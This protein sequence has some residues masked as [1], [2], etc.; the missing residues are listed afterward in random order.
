M[1]KLLLSVAVVALLAVGTVAYSATQTKDTL[2]SYFETGDV[3]TQ[4]EFIDLIDS[5]YRWTLTGTTLSPEDPSHTIEV[6]D[7]NVTGNVTGSLDM[8]ADVI[9][10]IGATNTNFTDVGGLN[11]GGNAVTKTVTKTVCASN[12]DN[13][14]QCD[15]LCDGTADDIQIQEALDAVDVVSK[16][17]VKVISGDYANTSAITMTGMNN[18]HLIFE[19]GAKITFTGTDNVIESINTTGNE[20]EGLKISGGEIEGQAIDTTGNGIHF[21]FVDDSVIEDITITK[22]G[23]GV[24]GAGIY[25]K[26]SDYNTIRASALNANRNGFLSPQ[27]SP[28]TVGLVIT[29]TDANSNDDDGIH[30]QRDYSSRVHDCVCQYN[31]ETGIDLWDSAYAVI[32]SNK[33]ASNGKRGI[34]LADGT[35]NAMV[36]SN[37]IRNNTEEGVYVGDASANEFNIVTGNTIRSNGLDGVM[38][39]SRVED[40]LIANNVIRDNGGTT[41]SGLRILNNT[42]TRRVRVLNNTIHDNG[43]YGVWIQS[44]TSEHEVKGNHFL[45]NGTGVEAHQVVN[46][47]GALNNISGNTGFQEKVHNF[48]V[49]AIT[50]ADN[51][52]GTAAVYTLNPTTKYASFTCSDSDGC[53]ITMGETAP[54]DGSVNRITNT[55]ANVCNFADSA[56]RSE[57]AGSFA[58]G[59]YDS[60]ELIYATDRWTEISRS[61]N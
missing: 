11:L 7:F 40:L 17:S 20:S 21:E 49:E 46:S 6:G 1:K 53:N 38:V 5:V 26:F 37:E 47:G 19:E 39:T 42:D 33:L 28:S 8:D 58:M 41:N 15:Y 14:I 32:T 9:T 52:L 59:Q 56:G 54:I 50:V 43:L 4:G 31:G 22:C 36:S 3:P 29:D 45:G 51:G 18:I 24:D 16:G 23:T 10:N 55:S 30:L 2:K 57:L 61:D 25:M 35:D 44:S 12:S 60:L 27:E 48:K 34:E 13:T